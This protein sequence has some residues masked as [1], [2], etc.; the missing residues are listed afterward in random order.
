MHLEVKMESR[1]K[2][3]RTELRGDFQSLFIQ[4]FGPPPTG[5][6]VT[7]AADKDKGVMG[8]PPGFLS[9]TTNLLQGQTEPFV[10]DGGSVHVRDPSYVAGVSTK[11]SRLECPKFD[12]DDFRG[13]WTKLEQY[14]EAEG[15]PDGS[16]VRM[17]MLNL[18]GRAL[19]W[20]HF[21]SQRNGGLQMLSWST[22]IKSLQDR[23][24]CGPFGDPMRELNFSLKSN[25]VGV[26]T[27]TLHYGAL[28]TS[29]GATA[30]VSSGTGCLDTGQ[31]MYQRGATLG[32]S[33]GNGQIENWADSGLAD[34]S[35]Q[36]DTSTDVDTDHKNLLHG[37]QYGAL[38]HKT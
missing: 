30:T 9:K 6:P 33:L 35:Q 17:A 22:Y 27:I 34:N 32:A 3:L 4:Y 36:T 10:P 29:F 5:L 13:W 19:E 12:G 26:V 20:H 37:V 21:Y 38:H 8:A 7:T 11:T 31:F 14:F 16:K 15:I 24:G 23:F 2:E 25:N 18:E 1:L 28:N